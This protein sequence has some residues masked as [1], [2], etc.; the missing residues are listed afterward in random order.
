[1]MD[2]MTPEQKAQYLSTLKTVLMDHVG[3]N[4]KIGMGELYDR[5]I[6]EPWQHR[7]NDTRRIRKLVEILQREEGIKICSDPGGYWLAASSSE[8]DGYLGRQ[9]RRALR[10]LAKE[11][12]IRRMAL[13]ALLGQIAIEFG[14]EGRAA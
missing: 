3:T 7:I 2:K 1:V 5:V 13:P 4:R 8:L 9:H 14:A 11:A 12:K 10:I 6:G